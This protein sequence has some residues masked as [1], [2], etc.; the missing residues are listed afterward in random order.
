VDQKEK[1][2]RVKEWINGLS[3]T[4]NEDLCVDADVL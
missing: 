1:E 2:K 3:T 4:S